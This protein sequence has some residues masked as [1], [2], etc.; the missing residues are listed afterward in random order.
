[1]GQEGVILVAEYG[2]G[3]PVGCGW[4]TYNEGRLKEI[5]SQSCKDCGVGE[6]KCPEWRK[7]G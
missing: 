1:M 2:N 4:Y 6:K 3:L 7:E 5:R